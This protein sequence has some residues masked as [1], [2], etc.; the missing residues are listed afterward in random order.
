MNDLGYW[1]AFTHINGI[2]T[3]KFRL[4]EK[5]FGSLD[6][7]WHANASA[8][9]AAGLEER[10]A[11]AVEE[12]RLTIHPDKEIEKLAKHSIRA[13]NWHDDF[14]PKRLKEIYDPPPVLFVK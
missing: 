3:V 6:R 7:A 5:H 10:L 12:K 8:L 14:Y 1:I 4:L 13:I 2:G 9:M 11:K